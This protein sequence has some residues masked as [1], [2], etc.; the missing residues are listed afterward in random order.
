[1]GKK[2]CCVVLAM[3]LCAAL[4]VYGRNGVE[5]KSKDKAT[6]YFD[7]SEE[8]QCSGVSGAVT[9]MAGDTVR[10]AGLGND[11]TVY[12]RSNTT[13]AAQT[14]EF[15]GGYT[16]AQSRKYGFLRFAGDG[17]T[18]LMPSLAADAVNADGNAYTYASTPFKFG[19]CVSSTDRWFMY[20]D[21]F[22]S[23]SIAPLKMTNP[24]FTCGI[25]EDGINYITFTKGVFNFCDPEGASNGST[26]RIGALQSIPSTITV[27]PDVTFKMAKGQL[28]VD[29]SAASVTT[30]KHSGTFETATTFVQKGGTWQI[31]G[32]TLTTPEYIISNGVVFATNATLTVGGYRQRNGTVTLGRGTTLTTSNISDS[33]LH[34]AGTLNVA[35]G[36]SVS[37]K[38]A[39]SLS[40]SATPTLS[41]MGGTFTA[42]GGIFVGNAS[43]SNGRLLVSGGR[44]DLAG[45]DGVNLRY[46]NA[47]SLFEV[48]GGTAVVSRVR[49]ARNNGSGDKTMRQTG[50]Y[51]DISS[52]SYGYVSFFDDATSR[53]GTHTIE[54]N[55]GIT[56]LRYIV[57]SKPSLTSPTTQLLANGGTLKACTARNS[58]SSPFIKD[59]K[60][61][62]LGNSGLTFDTAGN[63]I[64][65]E[66]N[67][68]NQGGA[69]GLLKKVGNGTLTYVGTS[70]VA[71]TVVAGGTLLVSGASSTLSTALTVTNEATFSL[72]GSATGATLSALTVTNASLALDA[73]DVLAVNGPVSV[74]RLTINWSSAAP[75]AA[76][77]F[78]RVSGELG[79]ETKAAIRSALFANALSD[80]TH[81]AYTFDYDAGTGLTTVSAR[82]ANDEP[83][84]D[85]V[86]WTGTGAWATPANW[87]GNAVP[88]ETQ[89]A[90]FTSASSGKTVS[91]AAGDVTGALA[92]GADG[93]TLTGMGPLSIAGEIGAAQI[94][95]NAGSN[96]IDVPVNLSV[97]TPV[98]VNAGATLSITK[99]ISGGSLAKTGTGK[100]TLGA[101]NA[102]DGGILSSD[103]I[104][105]AAAAGALGSSSA[106]AVALSGG[107]VQFAGAGGAEMNVPAN[108]SVS[109][110]NASDIVVFK[111][112]T[113]T[114]LDRLNVMQGAFC[115]RGTGKLTVYVPAATSY[116]LAVAGAGTATGDNT[117]WFPSGSEGIVFPDDGT[118][119]DSACGKYPGFSV[120]EGELALV[121]AGA[122]AGV[123]MIGARV[124]IGL[125]SKT[126]AAQP[127][128]TVDNVYLDC[129]SSHWFLGHSVGANNIAVT[130]PV[131]RI[132]NGGKVRIT[133][134]QIGYNSTS[135]R[136]YVTLAA[137]NGTFL[138]SGF[139]HYLTR[140]NGSVGGA[141]AYYK[142]KDSNLYLDGTVNKIG[143]GIDLDFDNSVFSTSA[144]GTVALTGES[145]RPWGTMLFRN[146]SVF[147]YGGFTENS[148]NKNLTFAFDDSELKLDAS[149]ASA[150]L[151]ASGSGKV[152]YEMRG[153][154]AVLKPASGATYTI[155]APLEGEGGLV[156][157]GEGTL[158]L[159][160]GKYAFSGT[161]DVRS[162][163]LDLSAAGSISN[164]RFAATTGGGTVSSA[165]LNQATVAIAL[166]DAWENTNGIPTF[167]NCTFSGK[168]KVDAGRTASNP[169]AMPAASASQPVAIARFSGT[170]AADLSAWRLVNTGDRMVRGE[171][172][173][174]DGTVYLTP[175]PPFGAV[176]ILR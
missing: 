152:H 18:F 138:V 50:G 45:G 111:A 175:A 51:L 123:S 169:L 34:S 21:E 155:N 148:I 139:D 49:L 129:L 15:K 78:L 118:A 57:N 171:F 33:Y 63:N 66:Q 109:A 43:T 91:V 167:A 150:T 102:L 163:T 130:N 23:T 79:N 19:C 7:N 104:L 2:T 121:G 70:D 128:L 170:T 117:A 36:A 84:S 96:T 20:N 135:S 165:V 71:N 124:L 134:S 52:A 161:C 81:A 27:A 141:R 103:G 145:D 89:I 162:G 154:G 54:L 4:S 164:P 126:C 106:D 99:T 98:Q 108:V 73:G 173:L 17:Y 83:L 76:T 77:P 48:S 144:G 127:M 86:T 93:Y 29:S 166:S 75:S 12:L 115:K 157:A 151:V 59:L 176:I 31:D 37:V 74:N 30:L 62:K 38:G 14:I 67:M 149:R 131:L 136:S 3:L 22:S 87:S 88:T 172:T 119:P 160:S 168:V 65:V 32:G 11:C 46:G 133:S 143:G 120:A 82:V 35:E 101:A 100:L 90:S 125:Y 132:I 40:G 16:S 105:E 112:D 10:M 156:L 142:F 5:F 55:G 69:S 116:T 1:M 53:T 159:A 110:A 24:D 147:A 85:S 25:T 114:S 41:I 26:L 97:R 140:M 58:S 6:H 56:A 9:P 64:Y 94:A 60:Y 80:G 42:S 122:D 8:W 72:V 95:A 61:M 174:V 92:F 28:S 146:G 107:T 13:L 153:A 68:S 137:T 39:V 158:A 113:D 47:A 44:F